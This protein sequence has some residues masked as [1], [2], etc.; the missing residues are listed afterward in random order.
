MQAAYPFIRG[1]SQL[2]ASPTARVTK[3]FYLC[4]TSQISNQSN[5]QSLDTVTYHTVADQTLDELSDYL[6]A[7][8][9]KGICH[10]DYDVNV[11]DGVLTLQLGGDMGTYVINKQTPNKQLWLSSPISGPKR[12]DF[13]DGEW[14]YRHDSISLHTRLS[15]EL[16]NLLKTDA[17]FN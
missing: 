9:D 10:P 16:A 6:E 11:S 1:L 2:K 4:V 7:I 8:Q 15:Q 13:L 5:S 3:A 12:Y 17:I 14:V